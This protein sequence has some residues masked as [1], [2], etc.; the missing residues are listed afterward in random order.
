MYSGFEFCIRGWTLYLRFFRTF[1]G[2]CKFCRPLTRFLNGR[3]Q[4]FFM[5]L[6]KFPLT[7]STSFLDGQGQLLNLML[8]QISASRKTYYSFLI[9]WLNA[10][11]TQTEQLFRTLSLEKEYLFLIKYELSWSSYTA[12]SHRQISI[13]TCLAQKEHYYNNQL[14]NFRKIY[15][16][17]KGK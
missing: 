6:Q 14:N 16:N 4:P 8:L 1:F 10:R 3:G 15:A 5:L 7:P 2:F 12:S 17:K 11:L 13:Q 9:S